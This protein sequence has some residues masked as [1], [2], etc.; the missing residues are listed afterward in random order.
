MTVATSHPLHLHLPD[1]PIEQRA[2]WLAMLFD[3]G[4]PAVADRAEA[5]GG[6]VPLVDVLTGEGGL[7]AWLWRRWRVLERAGFDRRAFD[8]VLAG[9]QREVWLWLMGQRTWVHCCS[10]LIGRLERRVPG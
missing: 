8:A 2:Q 9:Y 3:G 5:S 4:G 7:A 1:E 10:G 6:G